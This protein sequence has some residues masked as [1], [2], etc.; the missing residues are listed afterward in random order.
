MVF[1]GAT[2]IPENQREQLLEAYDLLEKFLE[3]NKFVAGNDVSIADFGIVTSINSFSA[4]V[5]IDTTKYP[6]IVS[7]MDRMQ[8]LPYYDD[9]NREGME[10]FRAMVASKFSQ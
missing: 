10:M 4:F 7:W 9:A 1:Q 5:P 3:S 6:K 2:E 8:K